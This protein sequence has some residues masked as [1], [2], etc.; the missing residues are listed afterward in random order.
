VKISGRR[1]EFSRFHS[2]RLQLG[3]EDEEDE[4]KP[5]TVSDGNF[6]TIMIRAI[7][8]GTYHD[9]KLMHLPFSP[10]PFTHG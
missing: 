5:V 4:R 7:A 9:C 10:T 3:K 8:P 1:S 2:E 6:V